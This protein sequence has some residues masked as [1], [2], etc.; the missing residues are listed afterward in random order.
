MKLKQTPLN[1]L[2]GLLNLMVMLV[3][4]GIL[5]DA[6]PVSAASCPEDADMS[7]SPCIMDNYNEAKK[8]NSSLTVAQYRDAINACEGTDSMTSIS[9]SQ[10][11][12]SSETG[13]C[14]NAIRSCYQN[15]ID[16]RACLDKDVLALVT[17]CNDGNVNADETSGNCGIDEAIDDRNRVRG[18][19]DYDTNRGIKEQRIKDRK[20][21]E[22]QNK[23][24]VSEIE[25]CEKAV[26]DQINACY[27]KLGGTATLVKDADL[28]NCMVNSASD[29]AQ[30]DARQ[31]N[32]DE[33]KSPKCSPKPGSNN[34]NGG[35]NNTTP[36]VNGGNTGTGGQATNTGT[37]GQVT[38]N[39]ISCT[40]S[41]VQ[42]IGDVLRQ[43]IV[44]L[45]ILIGIAAV[46]GIAYAAILYASATDN[47]S[48]T[49]KAIELIRNIVIG[50]LVYGFM[51]AIINWLVP[52]GVIG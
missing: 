15:A 50:I 51:V 3:G 39:L 37:C 38:T 36:P 20:A 29:K 9:D 49:Q 21:A 17:R 44:I 46:G 30:C 34:N 23:P 10:L 52:G 40:G 11:T 33:T 18:G 24:S 13:T 14:S 7:T 42:A 47:S 22:C 43:I 4:V 35:N 6:S 8:F 12:G 32:W 45:T 2:F 27:N 26:E 25:A 48:Q 5:F 1:Y 31:G 41:G 16:Q 28:N 19:D